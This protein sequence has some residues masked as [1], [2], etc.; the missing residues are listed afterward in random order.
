MRRPA[1]VEGALGVGDDRGD[2]RPRPFGAPRLV[3]E[4]LVRLRREQHRA[5][6]RP[7]S[8]RIDP[9]NLAEVGRVAGQPSLRQLVE[10]N[11]LRL[12]ELEEHGGVNLDADQDEAGIVGRAVPRIALVR[13]PQLPVLGVELV[14]FP[15]SRERVP[16]PK[17]RSIPSF[18][19]VVREVEVRVGLEIGDLRRRLGRTNQRSA[20]AARFWFAIARDS[21]CCRDASSSSS[22]SRS[23]RRARRTFRARTSR[24][25]SLDSVRLE[26]SPFPRQVGFNRRPPAAP[27]VGRGSRKSNGLSSGRREANFRSGPAWAKGGQEWY[28]SWAGLEDEFARK[29]AAD[30]ADGRIPWPRRCGCI[31]TSASSTPFPTGTPGRHGCGSITCSGAGGMCWVSLN[32]C[33]SSSGSQATAPPT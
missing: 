27:C 7:A 23:P 25:S 22:R 21:R 20:P 3:H 28:G 8:G 5:S 2:R 31:W 13:E 14:D 30:D 11:R 10:D 15:R 6:L 26:T 19:L 16:S 1:V 17:P 12:V 24:D 33:S 29:I 18:D 32:P 9:V 4:R